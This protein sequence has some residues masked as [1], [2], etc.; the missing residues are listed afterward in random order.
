M[1]TLR[2]S[3]RGVDELGFRSWYG[4]HAKR[5]KLDPDPDNLRR[6]YD[7]RRAFKDK[8]EPDAKGSWP[9]EYALSGMLPAKTSTRTGH[10]LGFLPPRTGKVN[11]GALGLH[12][13]PQG[14]SYQ[15]VNM[16]KLGRR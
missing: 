1:P 5:L 15:G 2:D 12:L 7:Y 16:R 11:S 9:P 10:A 14:R 4:R 13:S 6:S 3:R 8:V